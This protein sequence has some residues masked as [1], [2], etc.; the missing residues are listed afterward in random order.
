MFLQATLKKYSVE[1]GK[2]RINF[3]KD[4]GISPTGCDKMYVQYY[5][6]LPGG[7]QLPIAIAVEQWYCYK[8][9][10]I[11]AASEMSQVCSEEFAEA[12]LA[13]QML[14]GKIIGKM[15][16]AEIGDAVYT[17]TGRYVCLEIIG[18]EQSEEIIK[19]HEQSD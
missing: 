9:N 15:E 17:L 6:V 8:E 3:S 16:Q 12:Y 11:T 10:P 2:K 19:H 7:F 13:E 5:C 1:I 14:S 18:R 4:S